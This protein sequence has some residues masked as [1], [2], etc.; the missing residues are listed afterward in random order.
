MVKFSII[1][2]VFNCESYLD[3]CISSVVEQTYT[4]WELILVNDGSTDA[5]G[6]LCDAFHNNYPDKVRVMHQEN[7]GVLYA[8]RAGMAMASGEYLCFLDSDDYWDRDLLERVDAQQRITDADIIVFGYRMINELQ[9]IGQVHRVSESTFCVKPDFSFVYD[10]ILGGLISS[11]WSAVVRSSLRDMERDYSPYKGVFKGEDL[12][13]T[14]PSMIQQSRCSLSQMCCT[15]IISTNKD[16]PK[17]RSPRSTCCLT[18]SS[19]T[20]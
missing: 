2:P 4:N 6:A 7:A 18:C 5:S 13:R 12:Y 3:R 11:V 16:C 20:E 17:E 14:L 19:K 8:R 9:V 15:T 1:V 10:Q